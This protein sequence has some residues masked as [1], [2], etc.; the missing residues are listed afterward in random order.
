MN[1]LEQSGQAGETQPLLPPASCCFMQ[2]LV[3]LRRGLSLVEGWKITTRLEPSD[4]LAGG[5]FRRSAGKRLWRM[6]F[7]V[8]HLHR[9]LKQPRRA[10]APAATQPSA[11]D[12]AA[13]SLRHRKKASRISPIA[14][15][16]ATAIAASAVRRGFG[17]IRRAVSVRERMLHSSN[18]K[19]ITVFIAAKG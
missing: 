15:V 3:L 11:P 10:D 13:S 16:S 17:T 1:Q 14:V 12:Q 9:Q 2:L 8:V 5:P 18:A 4:G 7:A 6:I 19:A